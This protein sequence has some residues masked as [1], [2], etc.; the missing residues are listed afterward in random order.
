MNILN[1][2]VIEYIL[3]AGYSATYLHSHGLDKFS[4]QSQ[5]G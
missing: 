1:W 2:V 4:L 3:R 5:R